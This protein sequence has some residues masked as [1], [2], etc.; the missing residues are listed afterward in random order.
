MS[1]PITEKINRLK[2]EKQALTVTRKAKQ[3]ELKQETRRLSKLRQ[4][5][6]KVSPEDLNQCLVI[7]VAKAKAQA[8]PKA[9]PK[10]AAAPDAAAMYVRD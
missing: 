6:A 2:A 5:I 1:E 9:Q 7:A 10:A 8:K 4:V 3:K